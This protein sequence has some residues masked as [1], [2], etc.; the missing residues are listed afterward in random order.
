MK[1]LVR[2]LLVVLGAA[3]ALNASD[4][5][6]LTGESR[7]LV[8]FE[9][10]TSERSADWV[11]V[12]DTVFLGASKGRFE[13]Q[14]EGAAKFEGTLSLKRGGGWCSVRRRP[15]PE[16]QADDLSHAAALRL[17]VRGDGKP[18]G[19]DLRDDDRRNGTYYEA[20]LAT[21][22]GQWTTIDVP[23]SGFS[24]LHQGRPEP[25]APALDRRHVRSYGFVIANKQEGPF[26]LEV[27]WISLIPAK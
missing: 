3:A 20:P 10:G 13:V 2:C 5:P 22:A 4:I 27:G 17:H 25:D 6:T 19:F 8:S 9:K 26:S 11:S 15:V 12:N 16:L 18:Y 23:L 24:P 21:V 14:S 7:V 1:P